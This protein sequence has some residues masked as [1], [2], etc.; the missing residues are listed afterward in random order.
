MHNRIKNIIKITINLLLN[1]FLLTTMLLHLLLFELFGDFLATYITELDADTIK[2]MNSVFILVLV[3][4]L[5]KTIYCILFNLKGSV[6][7]LIVGVVICYIWYISLNSWSM[8]LYSDLDPLQNV[9][10]IFEPILGMSECVFV[11]AAQVFLYV[12]YYKTV[13]KSK[14]CIKAN[15]EK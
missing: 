11:V 6:F 7:A 2:Q 13:K 1:I 3:I 8:P 14:T 10:I 15:Q 4:L 12:N 5:S 9:I